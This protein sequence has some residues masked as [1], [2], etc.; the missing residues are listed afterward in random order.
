MSLPKIYALLA[1]SLEA[2]EYEVALNVANE[3]TSFSLFLL[4][5]NWLFFFFFF[6]NIT[7]IQHDPNNQEVK[8]IIFYLNRQ[9]L[10]GPD[11]TPITPEDEKLAANWNP[12][13]EEE[14]ETDEEEDEEEDTNSPKKVSP[15]K[16]SPKQNK[17][18]Q[19]PK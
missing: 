12:L 14:D 5:L 15:K 13:D 6:S 3:S 9:I 17:T 1:S 18:K 7:V 19:T 10:A 11:N 4:M 16:A 8:E 2:K